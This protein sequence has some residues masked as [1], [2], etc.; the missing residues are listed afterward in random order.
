MAIRLSSRAL[1]TQYAPIEQPILAFVDCEIAGGHEELV[2]EQLVQRGMDYQMLRDP[3]YSGGNQQPGLHD[4][5]STGKSAPIN[6]HGVA[7]LFVSWLR[8]RAAL[9]LV[10]MVRNLGEFNDFMLDEVRTI[11]GVRKTRT[12]LSF[13]G[14]AEVDT[15]LELEMEMS[16]ASV[17]TSMDHGGADH[18]P[19]V[20]A[21]AATAANVWINVQPGM[22]RT[23][24][25]ALRNLPDHPDVRQVWL[26][27]C[28]QTL[29]NDLNLLLLGKSPAALA[30]YVMSWIR[31]A[32]G[33]LNTEMGTVQDWRFLAE[34]D[35]LVELCGLFF[36]ANQLPQRATAA[37]LTSNHND[38]GTDIGN[39]HASPANPQL[40]DISAVW[41]Y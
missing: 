31:T 22:D 10:C 32:P 34:A 16:P 17:H 6:T 8:E 39:G 11:N 18:G 30:A 21:T 2:R 9:R 41:Q 28:Y 5:R 40:T 1:P 20:A 23:C 29:D 37:T 33:V 14:W 26:L 12:T 13:G 38:T 24:F 19:A 4:T 15:L 7:P 3:L 36:Q 25:A 27:H 35:D